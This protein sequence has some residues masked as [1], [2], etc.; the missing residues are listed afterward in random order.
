MFMIGI[1]ILVLSGA[2]ALGYWI[3]LKASN[4]KA[5]VKIIG[6]VIAWIIIVVSVI[7]LLL[8]TYS[9]ISMRGHC[10]KGGHKR[11]QHKRRSYK[12]RFYQ[13]YRMKKSGEEKKEKP[14]SEK[15]AE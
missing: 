12:G 8:S 5:T 10:Y 7:S 15:K 11:W 4:E 14:E 6:Q 2:L 1:P 9:R 3:M 13:K